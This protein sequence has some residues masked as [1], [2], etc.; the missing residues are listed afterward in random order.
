M[1][2]VSRLKEFSVAKFGVVQE[3]R[4]FPVKSNLVLSTETSSGHDT[5]LRKKI[6]V[7]MTSL[8]SR[9]SMNQKLKASGSLM[10]SVADWTRTKY[11]LDV[12]VEPNPNKDFIRPA[13]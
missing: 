12:W 9:K 1:N 7:L 10:I 5:F 11:L 8:L 2:S 6:H 4:L 3:K 13:R